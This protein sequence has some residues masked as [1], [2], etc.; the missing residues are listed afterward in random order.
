MHDI[1][2]ELSQLVELEFGVASVLL[3][4]SIPDAAGAIDYP[5][6]KNGPRYVKW[7]DTWVE[8]LNLPDGFVLDGKVAWAIRNALVHASRLDEERLGFKQVTFLHPK[9]PVQYNVVISDNG[10]GISLSIGARWFCEKVHAATASWLAEVHEDPTKSEGLASLLSLGMRSPNFVVGLPQ[11][12][13]FPSW[14]P[15][16]T[17]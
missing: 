11:I 8:E 5:D 14:P 6:L 15:P 1:L 10:D 3:A 4:L 17:G 13:S 7:F 2:N 9:S 12:G 16:L